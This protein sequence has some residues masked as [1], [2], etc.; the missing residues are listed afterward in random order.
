MGKSPDAFRTISEVAAFL[1]TPAHVLRFWESKFPQIKPVKRAGGRRYYRPDDIALLSGIKVLLH[2]QGMTIRGVQKLLKEKGPRHVA[3]LSA[4][5]WEG[6]EEATEEAPVAVIVGPWPRAGEEEPADAEAG[7]LDIDEESVGFTLEAECEPDP[8]PGPAP[9]ATP[10]AAPV[11]E[12]LA[13]TLDRLRAPVRASG[14]GSLARLREALAGAD[15][16]RLRAEAARLAP[17]VRRLAELRE[18]ASPSR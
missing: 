8:A 3:T 5:P 10:V 14:E 2:E 9:E 1:E 12:F 16:D 13:G 7:E 4:L 18:G 6:T 17:L 15:R 11:S